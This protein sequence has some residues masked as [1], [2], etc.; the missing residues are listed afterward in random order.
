MVLD[1]RCLVQAYHLTRK[2]VGKKPGVFLG[3]QMMLEYGERRGFQRAFADRQSVRACAALLLP[4]AA[5]IV[6]A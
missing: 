3:E 1:A 2:L 5:V 4:G 6:L